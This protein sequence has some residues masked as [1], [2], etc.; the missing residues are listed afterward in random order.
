MGIRV[1]NDHLLGSAGLSD[2]YLVPGFELNA[3]G[4]AIPRSSSFT[5]LI[6]NMGN[7]LLPT[8]FLSNDALLRGAPDVAMIGTVTDQRT[9]QHPDSR[10]RDHRPERGGA[11]AAH[12]LAVP[13][14]H[15][16]GD[17]AVPARIVMQG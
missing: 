2:G 4:G 6:V 7:P 16:R 9:V 3:L 1:L 12:P 14:E 17:R 13:R 8:S 11:A 10:D 5:G 15:M